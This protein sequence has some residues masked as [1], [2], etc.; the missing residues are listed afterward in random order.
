MRTSPIFITGEEVFSVLLY[1]SSSWQFGAGNA[2]HRFAR[3]RGRG[4]GGDK[5][6]MLKHERSLRTIGPQIATPGVVRLASLCG[7]HGMRQRTHDEVK[8]M[9]LKPITHNNRQ[10]SRCDLRLEIASIS[11]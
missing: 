11:A 1:F 10:C 5:C 7:K 2:R 4:V 3:L 6:G 8:S 9:G